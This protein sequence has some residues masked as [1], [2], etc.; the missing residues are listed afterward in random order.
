MAAPRSITTRHASHAPLT[1]R[2]R[3]T[4]AKQR[5]LTPPEPDLSQQVASALW[6][7]EKARAEIRR[8]PFACLAIGAVS[9]F[10]L[11]RYS[12]AVTQLAKSRAVAAAL[13]IAVRQLLK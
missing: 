7:G 3:A 4:L 12:G 13:P 1:P 8:H 10:V 5:L 6:C 9:G 11:T 2:Q